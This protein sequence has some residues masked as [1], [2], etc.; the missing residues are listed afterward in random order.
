MK[1]L[2]GSNGGRYMNKRNTKVILVVF[3]I[4][5]FCLVQGCALMQLIQAG[6]K[7]LTG[8]STTA[9]NGSILSTATT[10]PTA[11]PT[12]TPTVSATPT[13]TPSSTTS[14]LPITIKI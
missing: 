1:F 6:I 8:G 7:M 13:P 4:S 10:T 14:G 12:T 11:T 2:F 3:L 5:S 9:N